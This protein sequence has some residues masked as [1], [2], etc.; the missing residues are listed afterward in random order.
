MNNASDPAVLKKCL[1]EKSLSKPLK[2]KK[3]VRGKVT[4][5]GENLKEA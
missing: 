4:G 2:K 1:P 3:N 5:G